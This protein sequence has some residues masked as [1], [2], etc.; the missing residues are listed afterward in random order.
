MKRDVALTLYRTPWEQL[1]RNLRGAHSMLRFYD[2][3]YNETIECITLHDAVNYLMKVGDEEIAIK[4]G[5]FS[6]SHRLITFRFLSS[7]IEVMREELPPWSLI[8][9]CYRQKVFIKVV[10]NVMRKLN[11]FI[12]SELVERSSTLSELNVM[13]KDPKLEKTWRESL[14]EVL[15][16]METQYERK[17]REAKI[18]LQRKLTLLPSLIM[19][20][21]IALAYSSPILLGSFLLF[22][23]LGEGIN[24]LRRKSERMARLAELGIYT[25]YL[26]RPS[27][28]SYIATRLLIRKFIDKI[29]RR[30]D[31][32]FKRIWKFF[33][34][35]TKDVIEYLVNFSSGIIETRN[36][37]LDLVSAYGKSKWRRKIRKSEVRRELIDLVEELYDHYYYSTSTMLRALDR[38]SFLE[39]IYSP[40]SEIGT[41]GLERVGRMTRDGRLRIV[42]RNWIREIAKLN[43]EFESRFERKVEGDP[44]R[45]LDIIISPSG[46]IYYGAPYIGIYP[47]VDRKLM[48]GVLAKEINAY[49]MWNR[50]QDIIERIDEYLA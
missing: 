50:A 14:H 18:K 48:R 37:V 28:L 21:G 34:S 20:I 13:I 32:L 19:S 10:K 45:Y 33:P 30:F 42:N 46:C 2:P 43:G 3:N 15:K 47:C 1:S 9:S 31:K 40:P 25:T 17:V 35:S 8:S 36:N 4:L 7:E 26:F 12:S 11:N 44:N 27:S 5:V 23:V 41:F 49:L 22:Q 16:E 29:E 6:P 38:I 24:E 39:I